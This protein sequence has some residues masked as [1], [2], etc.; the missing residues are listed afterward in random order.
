MTIPTKYKNIPIPQDLH[1]K[2]KEQ[3]LKERRTMQEILIDAL[4]KYFKENKKK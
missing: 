4:V 3:S 1:Y 2:L